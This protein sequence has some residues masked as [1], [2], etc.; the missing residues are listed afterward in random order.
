MNI[1]LNITDAFVEDAVL[2][3][4][5]EALA[6]NRAA[7]PVEPRKE[8]EPGRPK[9]K[10]ATVDPEF[11]AAASTMVAENPTAQEKPAKEAAAPEKEAISFAV[12]A[13]AARK[14]ID[15]KK[16]DEVMAVLEAR[17]TKVLRDIPEEDYPAVLAE[18]EAL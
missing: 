11:E 1:N 5:L 17:G 4:V 6:G 2:L 9:G 14:A 18:I 7:K 13:K 15:A 12:V 8:A 10:P 3:A 16:R